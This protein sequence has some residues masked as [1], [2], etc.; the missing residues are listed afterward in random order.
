MPGFEKHMR[1]GLKAYAVL[2]AVVALVH[3]V[4]DGHPTL[5]AT[6]ATALPFTLAGAMFP[7][8]DAKQSIPFRHFRRAVAL[9]SAGV[10]AAVLYVSRDL[11]VAAGGLL[12]LTT[13]P[14]FLGG[15]VY[16]LFVV[17]SGWLIFRFLYVYNPPHRGVLHQLPAGVIVATVL[18][19]LTSSV[20]VALSFTSPA[21]IAALVSL[22]FLVGYLSH[23][24]LDTDP[25]EGRSLLLLRKT[26]IGERLDDRLQ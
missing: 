8:L 23:L 17:G 24:Y 6:G 15:I 19:S 9:F 4:G 20:T 7:D 26:Y 16:G 11:L 3:L 14:A 25:Q 22:G 13:S 21:A 10:V 12:P 2:P 1:G 18:F 5:L